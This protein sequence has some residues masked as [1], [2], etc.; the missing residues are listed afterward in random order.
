[1][2]SKDNFDEILKNKFEA[3]EA[4]LPAG[5]FDAIKNRI[6]HKRRR[7]FL[8]PLMTAASL[9]FAMLS[10]YLLLK[11]HDHQIDQVANTDQNT[12]VAIEKEGVVSNNNKQK[13]TSNI[14]NEEF[15]D[16][17]NNS[18]STAINT[19]ELLAVNTTPI[20]NQQGSNLNY[21]SSTQLLNQQTPG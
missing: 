1:M 7:G 14:N 8:L 3:Y 11:Q 2:P 6:P 4:P 13:Q 18:N 12:S 20:E 21:N 15:V 9:F 5:G 19:E 10:G 16:K 17:N